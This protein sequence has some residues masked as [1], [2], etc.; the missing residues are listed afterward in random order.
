MKR[1]RSKRAPRRCSS[2]GNS[3]GTVVRSSCPRHSIKGSALG[4]HLTSVSNRSSTTALNSRLA[5]RSQRDRGA[6]ERREVEYHD[7]AV[8]DD[9]EMMEMI[10][11]SL[12]RWIRI[13]LF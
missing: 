6:A 7:D 9:R 13:G 8:E 12:D 10:E 5:T 1:S 3:S 4:S 11:I 2:T